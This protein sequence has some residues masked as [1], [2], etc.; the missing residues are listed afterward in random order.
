MNLVDIIRYFESKYPKDLA[1]DWD[2][3]GIQVG[4]LNQKAKKVLISLDLTKEVVKEAIDLKVNMILTHH[5]LMF[6]PMDRIVFDSPKGWIVKNLIK[7]NITVYSAHTNYD[8]A[9]GGMNDTLAKALKIKNPQLL[10][11]DDEIGRYGD[12]DPL[13]FN[14][15]IKMIKK[16]LKLE[17]VKVVGREDKVVKTIGVSGGSGSKHMYEAKRVGCDVYLTGDVTYHTALDAIALG[18]TIVDIGHHAEKIFVPAVKA[19]L[20]S[21]FEEVEFIESKI[22]TDPFKTF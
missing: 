20:E 7:H 1:Y 14:D 2:N 15:F 22:N 12:I 17:V 13:A 5:P 16:Q 10:D 21:Q 18:L 4:T 11:M 9:N 6:K 8:L 3:V 19:D